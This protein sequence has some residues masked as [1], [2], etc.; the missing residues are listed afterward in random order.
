MCEDVAEVS[1][2]APVVTV[3]GPARVARALR[4]VP[5]KVPALVIRA[6]SVAG[7]RA[8]TI[9]R[10]SLRVS[11]NLVIELDG[12]RTPFERW[13]GKVA[14]IPEADSVHVTWPQAEPGVLR[15]EISLRE[16]VV[17]ADAARAVVPLLGPCADLHAAGSPR[18]AVAA[19]VPVGALALLPEAVARRPRPERLPE[20]LRGTDVL[21][22]PAPGTSS[23]SPSDTE[24][25]SVARPSR[26]RRTVD[27]A[28]ADPA[29]EPQF[30][31]EVDARGQIVGDEVPHSVDL[32]VHNP[33]GW[34][35]RPDAR[36]RVGEIVVVGDQLQLVRDGDF[37]VTRSP[38]T[39]PL[40]PVWVDLL[41]RYQAISLARVREPRNPGARR[42]LAGRL[43]ELAACGPII[44]GGHHLHRVLELLDA[45]LA[46]LVGR[47]T[48]PAEGLEMTVH[49]VRQRRAAMRAHAGFFALDRAVQR[50]GFASLMP[51]VT[52]LLVTN[53]PDRIYSALHQLRRQTYPRFDVVV[54][55]HGAALPQIPDDLAPLVSQAVELAPDVPFGEALATA[56]ALAD[57]DLLTKVDDDDHYGPEH[58]WDLVLAR[59]FSGATVVG[60]QPEYAHLEALELTVQRSFRSE[61]YTEAVAG[62]TMLV[63]AADL[64]AVGGWRGVPRSVDRALLQRVL[65]DGGLVYATNA[66]GFIY[67]RH[68]SGHTWSAKTRAFLSRNVAQWHGLQTELLEPSEG[69]FLG[70][71]YPRRRRWAILNPATPGPY[72]DKWGDTPFCESLAH[73]LR[74]LGQDVTVYRRG[75]FDEES[76]RPDVVL[77]VRGLTE[78]E[79]IPGGLN[80]LWVISHPDAVTERELEGMDLVFAASMKWA[81]SMSRSTQR[82]VRPLLQA[83]DA[84]RFAPA[85]CGVSASDATVFVGAARP[86]NPRRVVLDAVAAGLELE[87]WGPEW[88]GLVPENFI[89]GNYLDPAHLPDLYARATVVLADHHRDM[90]REGFIA[91]RIFEAVASGA[92]VVSDDV[93]GVDEIFG[94][95]VKVCSSAE[96]F[97]VLRD[98]P[99]RDELVGDARDRTEAADDVRLEHSFTAR[100]ATLIGAVEVAE[101]GS[102]N[103]ARRWNGP[104]RAL[105]DTAAHRA[106][107]ATERVQ[108]LESEIDLLRHELEV[109]LRQPAE[110]TESNS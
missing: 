44:H 86:Q 6:R 87:I 61:A 102:P 60:K 98:G 37:V 94:G 70:D 28:D 43:A 30:K 97:A 31:V 1:Q 47:S 35:Q 96:E 36:A 83:V 9:V 39:R 79:P 106:V 57:G 78:A 66:H 21:I 95:R 58:V 10:R 62:G 14:S 74:R 89:A 56:S 54:V 76:P 104:A 17:V 81:G 12:Y 75:E 77:W 5:A 92:L 4:G 105:T 59:M 40:S 90:A 93:V 16:P 41:H 67:V 109:R 49:G 91:N 15:V 100:A 55:A 50:L 64:G 84:T 42:E 8:L 46:R 99:T 24:A 108:A 22:V 18:V 53:R 103:R 23:G 33:T 11:R 82:E 7:L 3:D 85:D 34:V 88:S 69:L 80:V 19:G 63:S 45:E 73:A 38:L 48:R 68:E 71:G 107:S 27:D 65:E 110:S 20:V 72:G 32:R 13:R 29:I 25:A 101:R 2:E 51:R 52:A 26:R